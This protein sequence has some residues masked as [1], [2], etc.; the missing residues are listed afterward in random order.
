[1][2]TYT[3]KTF[4]SETNTKLNMGVGREKPS[5]KARREGYAVLHNLKSILQKLCNMRESVFYDVG[6]HSERT[7]W[8]DYMIRHIPEYKRGGPATAVGKR[9]KAKKKD[10]RS[11]IR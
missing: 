8:R 1:M 9:R 7:G 11:T 10:R 6:P 2:I 4:H 5:T 3:G